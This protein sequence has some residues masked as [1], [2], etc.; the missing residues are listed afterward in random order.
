MNTVESVEANGAKETCVIAEPAEILRK[1]KYN[2]IESSNENKKLKKDDSCHIYESVRVKR[3]GD[4]E[5]LIDDNEYVIVYTDG[6]CENNGK[7]NAA[8]GFGVYFNDDH[9]L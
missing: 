3:F 5:F 7:N 9:P 8:A 4:H 6:A 2:I 1:R